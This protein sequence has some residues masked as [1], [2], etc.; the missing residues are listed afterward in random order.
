MKRIAFLFVFALSAAAVMQ[1]QSQWSF[2]GTVIRMRM[3]GCVL[4]SGFK[5]SFEANPMTVGSCPEYT[6]MS[7]KVVYVVVG[8]RTQAFIPLAEDLDFVIRDNEIVNF[9][10]DEKAKS[11]FVIQQMMLRGDWDREQERKE[12]EARVMER[13]VSYEVRNPPRTTMASASS[14]R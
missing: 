13:S 14:A 7:S 12:L 1:A 10:N 3:T 5:A 2:K 9:S 11:R 8:R 4:Q 6:V